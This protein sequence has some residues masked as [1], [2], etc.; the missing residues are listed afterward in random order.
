MTRRDWFDCLD[1]EAEVV[2]GLLASAVPLLLIVVVVLL[3]LSF[4]VFSLT[5]WEADDSDGLEEVIVLGF[6]TFS[7]SLT[8]SILAAVVV[9]VS[10]KSNSSKSLA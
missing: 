7:V 10:S 1:D 6:T 8:F 5:E 4:C 2:E 3:V 9:L